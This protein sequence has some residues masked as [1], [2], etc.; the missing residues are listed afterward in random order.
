MVVKS[1]KPAKPRPKALLATDQKIHVQQIG[2]EYVNVIRNPYLLLDLK[3]GTPPLEFHAQNLV[4]F[5]PVT[6]TP[7]TS[8]KA[9]GDRLAEASQYVTGVYLEGDVRWTRETGTCARSASIM[10]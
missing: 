5:S 10:I 3:D 7:T 6:P 9:P 4:T 8:P 1:P 2:N